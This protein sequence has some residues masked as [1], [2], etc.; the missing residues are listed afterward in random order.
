MQ[1]EVKIFHGIVL[2]GMRL[3]DKYLKEKV[4]E[5]KEL[6]ENPKETYTILRKE[7]LALIERESY[8]IH[9]TIKEIEKIDLLNY[10]T[11][12]EYKNSLLERMK[13]FYN[14]QGSPPACYH[15]F[16]EKLELCWQFYNEFH[17]EAI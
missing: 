16:K 9:E 12:E 8:H 1:N 4:K 2:F 5:Y 15:I 11:P 10:K 14:E 13:K 17:K 7:N 3:L 6:A